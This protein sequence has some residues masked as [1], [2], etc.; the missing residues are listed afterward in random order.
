MEG[1]DRM[2]TSK[3][4]D[5]YKDGNM[6]IPIYFLKNYKKWNLEL[7]EFVFLMYF[8]HLGNKFVLD[9]GKF[10]KELNIPLAEVMQMIDSLTEKKLIR[11]EVLKNDKGIMEEVILLDD[12]YQ[13]VS[14]STVEEVTEE[15]N[16]TS[17]ESTIYSAIEK[18]FGRTLSPIEYEIIK[19]WLD[20]HIEEDVIREALK[21]ATFNGVSNLRYIDKILYDWGKLGIHSAKDVEAMRKKKRKKEEKEESDIDLGIM[22]WNWFDEDE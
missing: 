9:P 19:A 12:F 17:E 6:V 20:D 3:I 16:H 8:Y 10:S 7:S 1:D 13:K 5:L 14:L 18:E 4:I 21:E 15:S 11:V 22:D 2:K